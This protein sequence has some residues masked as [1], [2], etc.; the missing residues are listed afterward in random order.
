MKLN[1][2]RTVLPAAVAAAIAFAGCSADD[3]MSG[4]G[5]AHLARPRLRALPSAINEADVRSA[6]MMIPHH[7]QPWT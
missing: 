4:V 5:P 6:Q 1:I 2:F 3:S 7:E